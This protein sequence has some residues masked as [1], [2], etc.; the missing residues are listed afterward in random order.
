MALLAALGGSANVE[1]IQV[2]ST[3]L[4]VSLR[5]PVATAPLGQLGIKATAT[6]SDHCL[7]LIV[8]REAASLG[9]ALQASLL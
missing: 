6:P 3:R 4:L 5:V 9:E 2:A 8:G 7:H 1:A